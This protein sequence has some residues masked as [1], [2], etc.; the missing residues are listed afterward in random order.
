MATQLQPA[1]LV[2]LGLAAIGNVTFE[3]CEGEL[4]VYVQ[5]MYNGMSVLFK[6]IFSDVI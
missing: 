6:N 5:S 2:L 4:T 1:F 3:Q